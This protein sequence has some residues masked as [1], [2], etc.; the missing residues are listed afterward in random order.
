MIHSSER[1]LYV[2][3]Y[4]T[5][6]PDGTFLHNVAADFTVRHGWNPIDVIC[7]VLFSIIYINFY[8]IFIERVIQDYTDIFEYHFT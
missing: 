2:L 4:P 5:V 6:A 8:F 7:L 1:G 3:S